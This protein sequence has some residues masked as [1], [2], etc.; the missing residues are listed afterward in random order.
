MYKQINDVIKTTNFVASELRNLAISF[1]VTGNDRMHDELIDLS[2]MLRDIDTKLTKAYQEDS[3][4]RMNQAWG[5][6]GN[7]L[8]A[9]IDK[10]II[11]GEGE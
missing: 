9:L 2:C 5:N 1:Y 10:D 3:S 4:Q 11:E 7:V 8:N 6:V